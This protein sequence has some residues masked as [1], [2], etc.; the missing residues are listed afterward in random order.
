[1]AS[2]YKTVDS[3]TSFTLRQE[4]ESGGGNFGKVEGGVG[5][6][7]FG[8]VGHITSDPA[9]LLQPHLNF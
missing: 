8:K 5:A 2:C 6:G 1:M 7:N 4:S 9:T 3:Q